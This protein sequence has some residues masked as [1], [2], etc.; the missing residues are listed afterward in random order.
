MPTGPSGRSAPP[1]CSA[2]PS[3]SW[4]GRM[5]VGCVRSLQKARGRKFKLRHCLASGRLG[6]LRCANEAGGLPFSASRPDGKACFPKPPALR[7]LASIPHQA[8]EFQIAKGPVSRAF[9]RVW[10]FA[11]CP[12]LPCL[13]KPEEALTVSRL[14]LGPNSSGPLGERNCSRDKRTV[15]DTP[16]KEKDGMLTFRTAS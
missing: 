16:A 8:T 12:A 7:A 1:T 6:V 10:P 13:C 2:I 15:S 3:A 4:S 9:A 14:S 5:Q 11:P